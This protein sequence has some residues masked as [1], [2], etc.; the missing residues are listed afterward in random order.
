MELATKQDFDS[1]RKQLDQLTDLVKILG[2]QVKVSTVLYVSDIASLER[3]S[4]TQIKREPWLLPDFGQSEYPT[5]RCRWSLE[6]YEDWR[7]L[8]VA[9]R[10]S[11]WDTKVDNTIRRCLG[12]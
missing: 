2:R 8:P 11:M 7:S 12:E 10:K 6:K 3:M 4:V 9:Q 5:G 1:L